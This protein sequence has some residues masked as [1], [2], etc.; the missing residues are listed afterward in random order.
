MRH[1]W[2]TP[3]LPGCP[4]SGV[5]A[6]LS[7]ATTPDGLTTVGWHMHDL[8]TLDTVALGALPPT[9]QQNVQR[10]AL[11]VLPELLVASATLLDL[12]PFP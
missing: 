10:Q 2:F 4:L 1:V 3:P 5:Y 7:L 9:T 12:P 6:S 11:D 8:S